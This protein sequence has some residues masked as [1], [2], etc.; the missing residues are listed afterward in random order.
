MTDPTIRKVQPA[1]PAPDY[2]KLW[3][4]TPETCSEPTNLGPLQGEIFAQLLKLQEMEQ[5][6]PKGNN[7]DKI[8]FLGEFLSKISAPNGEQKALAGEQLDEFSDIFAQHRFGVGYN[9]DLKIKLTP[10][11]S[12]PIY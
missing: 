1:K 12:I 5:L 4:P 3:F 7:Q 6:V 8:A 11:R 9:T 2:A 10:E